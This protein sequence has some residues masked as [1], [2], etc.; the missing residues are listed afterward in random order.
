MRNYELLEKPAYTGQQKASLYFPV[1]CVNLH[2]TRS[3]EEELE[4]EVQLH[5]NAWMWLCSWTVSDSKQTP[6]NR[7][8]KKSVD[9]VGTTFQD[10]EVSLSPKSPPALLL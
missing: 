7:K 4:V 9:L 2:M 10:P 1:C 3:N 5:T 6:D 8:G